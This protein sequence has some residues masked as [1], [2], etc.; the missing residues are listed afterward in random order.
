[1]SDNRFN[2]TVDHLAVKTDDMLRDV[3]EYKKIGFSVESLH[4]DWAMMRDSRGFGI[5]LW[6]PES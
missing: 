5:A 3:E 2:G 4:D 1:M 6:P